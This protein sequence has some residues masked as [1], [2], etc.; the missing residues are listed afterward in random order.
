[1]DYRAIFGQRITSETHFSAILDRVSAIGRDSE[2]ILAA[3]REEE[4]LIKQKL[5][6][7]AVEARDLDDQLELLRSRIKLAEDLPRRLERLLDP[8]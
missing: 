3:A 5:V 6:Q 8:S 2:A 4:A 1:M 7:L